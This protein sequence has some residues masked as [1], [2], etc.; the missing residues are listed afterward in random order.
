MAT[1]DGVVKLTL[2]PGAFQSGMRRMTSMVKSAGIKM[3]QALKEPMNKGIEAART[4]M[5][6][7]LDD[8]TSGLKT[9]ATL[10]G[11]VSFGGMIRGAVMA[12]GKYIALAHSIE[13]YSKESTTA[14]QVQA[15]MEQTAENTGETL[16]E[17]GITM[18]QLAAVPGGIKNIAPTLE[19]ATMQA[20][21]LGLQGEFVARVY[22]RLMAKGLADTAEEA[23]I[24]TEKINEFGRTALGID[25]DEAID[26]MDVAE[27]AAFIKRMNS[28][29]D[30]SQ[31]LLGMTGDSVK[32]LGQALMFFEEMGLALATTEGLDNLRKATKL[33]KDDIN[34]TKGSVENLLVVLEKKGPKAFKALLDSFG[35][36]EAKLALSEV[37]GKE[38]MVKAE[39]GELTEEEWQLRIGGIR[40]ELDKAKNSVFNYG[41]IVATDNKLKTGAMA[42]F[43]R[44][45]NV[46][47][48]ALA[49]ER[50]MK[51]IGD[52]SKYLPQLAE[53]I[54]GFVSWVIS[55]PGQAVVAYI[56]VKVGGVFLTTA[57]RTAAA[58]GM[59]KLMAI[60]AAQAAASKGAGRLMGAGGAG[61]MATTLGGLGAAA[62][63]GA[64]VGYGI[65][66]IGAKPEL[67]EGFDNLRDAS[68]T[69]FDVS[70]A[71]KSASVEK[72]KAALEDVKAKLKVM[73]EGPG[74]WETVTGAVVS[75][76]SDIGLTSE[77]IKA[78]AEEYAAKAEALKKAQ[79]DLIDSIKKM[80]T[81][82]NSAGDNL[83]KVGEAAGNPAV[84]GPKANLNKEPGATGTK[85]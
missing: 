75:T 29:I 25:V 45:M 44:A 50:M 79:T 59:A 10:G 34:L 33:S 38:I 31:A 24:L 18:N 77:K 2:K 27:Y 83:N 48:S 28:G 82:A 66:E 21:R 37:I 62:G 8:L 16:E 57:V 61:A 70:T 20:K 85:G 15:A 81:A 26:P 43:K 80:S 73:K 51:A 58:S 65:Y 55:R 63:V 64:A 3:G 40:K 23:E 67:T 52:M 30:E 71:M 36:D 72:K 69:L 46:L 11:A 7:M 53:K 14:A 76:A 56:A 35:P 13:T 5:S 60:L 54:A 42:N 47:S 68:T 4:S 39:A 32:D 41:R 84:R 74:F 19:R 22:T 9:A 1:R 12:R 78:P 6:N 17:L 49:D